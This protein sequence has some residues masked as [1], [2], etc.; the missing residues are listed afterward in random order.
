MKKRTSRRAI[1]PTPASLADL[2]E[3]TVSTGA[4]RNPFAG[5]L[6]REGIQIVH[7]GPSSRSLREIPEVAL[8]ERARANPYSRQL[9][10]E[11]HRVRVGRGRPRA[12]ESVGPS[13]V[14]SV[15]LP[16][17]I[18]EALEA[19]AA[20]TKLTVHGVLRAAITGF[21]QMRLAS[22]PRSRKKRSG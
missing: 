20:A 19:E 12:G 14:R 13:D 7:D 2:P 4:R 22:A 18:W 3:V 9:A 10:S 1:D 16:M 5:Q 6:A 17:A 11:L 8:T 21:L 15:R